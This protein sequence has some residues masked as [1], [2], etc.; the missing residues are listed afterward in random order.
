MGR[1]GCV[2]S[3]FWHVATGGYYCLF[4]EDGFRANIWS[5]ARMPLRRGSCPSL[6]QISTGS[7]LIWN[8][9]GR[10]GIIIIVNGFVLHCGYNRAWKLTV[11]LI[12]MF[13]LFNGS[14]YRRKYFKPK[15][16]LL[17]IVQIFYSFVE[18]VKIPA[19]IPYYLKIILFLI[20]FGLNL[21]HVVQG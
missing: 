5:V 21:Q 13:K 3:K 7:P 2:K 11:P 12:F 14:F 16:D 6:V 18:F 9:L 15:F 8:G 4:W 1:K 17:N 19:V 20:E 10:W